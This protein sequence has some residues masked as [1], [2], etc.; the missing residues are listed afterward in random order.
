M[1]IRQIRPE[2]FT[3]PVTGHLEPAVQVAYIGLWCVADDAGWIDWDA[4]QVAAMLYPYKSIRVRTRVLK[5]AVESLSDANRLVFFDCGC[6]WIP[7]LANHQRIGGNKS[8]TARD[9]HQVHTRMD[10]PKRLPGRNTQ[11]PTHFDAES[12]EVHTGMDLSAGRVGNVSNGTRAT[13]PP[14]GGAAAAPGEFKERMA[15]H[16]VK[17][18]IAAKP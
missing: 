2:F 15:A 16:G 11:I 8:F 13:P 1:R 5:L 18:S 9:R 12:Q 4:D 7:N 17:E 10:R 3:D 6:A 14:N